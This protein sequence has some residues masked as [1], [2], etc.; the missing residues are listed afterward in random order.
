MR[1]FKTIVLALLFVISLLFFVQ[2]S[3]SLSTNL[4]LEFNLVTLHLISIPLPLYLF[5]LVAFLLGVVFTL[6][7]LLVERIRLGL[8]L[9]AL[10]RQHASL[11]DE[12][13][14][15]R[16]LPLNQPENKPQTG[17]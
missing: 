16:T 11:E 4:Q 14:A 10:R 17:N 8:E 1:Y 2:N 7:F 13:L 6:G 12:A 9:K 15:L 3:G 5:V